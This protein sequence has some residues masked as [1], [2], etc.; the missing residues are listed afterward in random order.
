MAANDI[1]FF[2][3]IVLNEGAYFYSY[4]KDCDEAKKER[5]V[6]NCFTNIKNRT[7]DFVKISSTIWKNVN[8]DGEKQAFCSLLLFSSKAVPSFMQNL[9]DAYKKKECHIGYVLIIEI[10][11]YVIIF[12]RYA[13]GINEF[14]N[15]LKPMNGSVLTGAMLRADSL[16]TKLR[17]GSMSLNPN[18]LRNRSFESNDL[19]QSMP[20]FGL[21]QSVVKTTRIKQSN[22][23]T[24]TITLSTSRVAKFGS[25]KRNISE[26]C[27]WADMVI[28]GI[29][30]PVDLSTTM[31]NNF[32]R[33]IK[34]QDE[35]VNL[36]PIYLLIDIHELTNIIAE[37][38]V[39][40]IYL[41]AKDN[42]EETGDLLNKILAKHCECFDLQEI[43]AHTQYSCKSFTSLSIKVSKNGI[44]LDCSGRLNNLFLRY[45]SGEKVRMTTF[46]NSHKCFYVGF[47]N[48]KY[49]YYGAQLHE[50]SNMKENL[51]SIL[52][53]FE[54]VKSMERVNTEKGTI[55]AGSTSFDE[56]SVFRV[57][58]DFY[59][60]KEASFLIC[61]DMG[62][63]CADHIAICGETLSFIHSK[64]YGKTS[65]SASN[66][67]V[68]IGQAIKNIGNL[69][70]LNVSNKIEAWRDK[71]YGQTEIPICRKG[72]I[73]EFESEYNKISKSPN[74]IKEVCLAIDFISLKSLS[75]AFNKIKNDESFKQKN[76][77]AQMIWLLS[78]F[79]S[80]C[81]DADMHCR[82]LCKE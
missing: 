63:E 72:D 21:G 17:L 79:I 59:I 80:A 60:Q 26:L 44:K 49:I 54:P 16:F 7:S 61:D 32:S 69:R 47:E 48:V 1:V 45:P 76:S 52:S 53:I 5:D 18:A 64:A 62:N 30:N 41:Q 57:V 3:G 68:V 55:E 27:M 19:N 29:K 66:F 75:S 10:E 34:W 14:K 33:P 71:K 13:N 35:Y 50:D 20:L 67:Q 25:S 39:E 31:L 73:N 78:A 82:I 56:D 46:I 28:T 81:K 43:E 23:D 6:K 58:E 37:Q 24:A 11:N 74:G 51:D 40:L 4:A 70:N 38:Q 15:K 8:Y 65:L 77:V 22:A 12:S 2:E 42:E 36:K 9:D